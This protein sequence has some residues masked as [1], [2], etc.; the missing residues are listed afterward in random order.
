MGIMNTIFDM[1]PEIN[2]LQALFLYALLAYLLTWA[3]RSCTTNVF[4]E[5]FDIGARVKA[6]IIK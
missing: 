2:S 3:I 5:Q 1:L 6:N 4:E